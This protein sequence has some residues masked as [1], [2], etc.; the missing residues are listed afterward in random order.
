MQSGEPRE[1]FKYYYSNNWVYIDNIT[2][3]I[4]E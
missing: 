1:T 3:S 4:A 2:V